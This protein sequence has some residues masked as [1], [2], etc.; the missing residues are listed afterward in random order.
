VSLVDEF[1]QFL[2]RGNLVELAVAIVIGVAF[3]D[4]VTAFVE[5]L[6]TPLIAA[7]GGQPDFSAL[8]FTING[9]TFLYGD[10]INKLFTFLMISLVIF[11]FVVKPV[12]TLVA[13]MRR[14]PPA[15]PTVRKCPHCLNTIPSAATRCGFCTS[16]LT[17]VT[18]AL[19]LLGSEPAR[20]PGS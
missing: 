7:V 16:D 14:E 9:S 15:D 18:A 8:D 5:D 19:P 12:N 3:A 17:P 13:R 20:S 10:F 11:L 6:I 2:F 4:L 1:K